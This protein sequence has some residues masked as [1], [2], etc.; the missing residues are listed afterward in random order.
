MASEASGTSGMFGWVRIAPT[1]MMPN[2][3]TNVTIVFIPIAPMKVP[4]SRSNRSSHLGHLFARLNQPEKSPPVPQTGHRRVAPRI[5]MRAGD[6][7]S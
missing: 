1:R 2:S 7:P 6:T 4:G 5:R 3:E